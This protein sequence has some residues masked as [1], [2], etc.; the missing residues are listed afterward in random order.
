MLY[1]YHP[2]YLQHDTG[3]GHPEKAQRLQAINL[4]VDNSPLCAKITRAEPQKAGDEIIT[5]VHDPAYYSG[6]AKAI[7]AEIRFL[8]HG[9]TVVS[10]GSLQAAQY[11][12][13][14]AVRAVD[15]IGKKQE[16]R[17]FCAVRPPGHH[18]EK[19][20]AMGFCLLN[21]VAIAARYAQKTGVA[22]NVLI[23][24][25]DVHHGNGTQHLFEEDDSVFYYSMHQY[26]F[27]PGTG[28]ESE[29]GVGRGQGFT[30]NRPL[31]AGCDDGDYVTAFKKDLDLI[32]NRFIADLV[33]VSAG[34]D[35]HREDPLA[36]M[37]VSEEGFQQ[38]TELLLTYAEKYSGGNVI[39]ILE[40]GYNL[41]ALAD[42]VLAHLTCLAAN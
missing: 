3:E 33:L 6:I 8:D 22:R 14:A 40:G 18:A 10:R 32:A 16:K 23:V 26:P 19:D 42:S 7:E 38:M 2:L 34:F 31:P 20:H 21:N 28:R 35:A 29:T 11:A 25:W 4:G 37:M 39:S 17:V 1:L 27:Y 36:G 30:L 12:A 5:L 15:V 13:G 41:R 9:D 24:D